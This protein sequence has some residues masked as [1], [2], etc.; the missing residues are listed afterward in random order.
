M[1]NYQMN[2]KSELIKL[3]LADMRN[4]KL[5]MGLDAIGLSSDDFNTNLS[6]LIFEKMGIPKQYETHMNNWYEDMIYNI[7]DIDLQSFR[8]HQ[9]FLAMTLYEGLE[10]ECRNL[11]T[12][13]ILGSKPQASF[14]RIAKFR[15][16][17]N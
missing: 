11:Q 9:L 10:E 17:D 7:L 13:C 8:E 4:R 14:L 5:I 2:L 1:K 3:I 16:F 6:E 15:R 12:K